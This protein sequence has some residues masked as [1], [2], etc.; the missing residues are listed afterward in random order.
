LGPGPRPQ[1]GAAAGF[2]VEPKGN[3]DTSGNT[4]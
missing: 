2:L 1:T 3:D 4:N